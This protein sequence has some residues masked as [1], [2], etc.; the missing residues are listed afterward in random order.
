MPTPTPIPTPVHKPIRNTQL[1]I[2]PQTRMTEIA[3]A[4]F[5]LWWTVLLLLP[6]HL[7]ASNLIFLG[8]QRMSSEHGWVLGTAL[9]FAVQ[10]I[11]WKSG[12]PAVR[13]AGC[14]IAGLLWL[15]V[16]TGICIGAV[17]WHFVIPIN[18]GVMA[19]G[20]T[21]IINLYCAA[22]V[23]PKYCLPQVYAAHKNGMTH[24]YSYINSAKTLRQRVKRRTKGE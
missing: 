23:L 24:I 13:W 7:F 14:M 1:Y 4:A 8:L 18:T 22:F 11:G 12:S 19:Y 17:K 10:I 20:A 15:F 16:T 2:C 5:A 9:T 3:S 6:V 21:G